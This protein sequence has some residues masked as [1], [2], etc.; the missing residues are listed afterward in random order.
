MNQTL[1]PIGIIIVRVTNKGLG[2]LHPYGE[3]R[4]TY[5]YINLVLEIS[6]TDISLGTQRNF[7]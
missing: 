4:L 2:M 3:V 6:V 5:S 7:L 1:V